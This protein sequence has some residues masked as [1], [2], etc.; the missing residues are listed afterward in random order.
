MPP[1]LERKDIEA[2]A[3]QK[4][5]AEPDGDNVVLSSEPVFSIYSVNEQ[6]FL[7]FLAGLAAL[8][9][10]LS[11]NV[12]YSAL[13][14]LA[15]HFDTSLS[16][17]NLTITTYL[18]FQGAAPTLV[19]SLSD[20][21]GRRPLYLACFVVYI[22]ANIGLATQD[23]YA[24]LLVLRMLQSTGSSG[25]VAL[26]SALVSDLVTSAQRGS[27]ISYVSMTAMVGPSFGPVIGGLLDEYL[28]WRAIFWFLTIFAGATFVLIFVVLPETCR[29]VVGNGSVPAP[30]WNTSV[31]SYLRLRRQRKAGIQPPSVEGIAFTK[32]GSPIQSLY[33]LFDKE[34]GI[35]LLYGAFFFCGFYM[36]QTGLPGQLQDNYGYNSLRIGLC[37]IPAGL[38]SMSASFVMG[39]FLDF[40]FKRHA[41]RLGFEFSNTRQQDLRNFP[42]ERARLEVV[43][44]LAFAAGSTV[45]ALG[46]CMEKRVF[47]AAPLVFLF[48]S[49]FF[50][51]STSSG[52][53]TMIVD[54]NRENPSSATAAMNLARCWLGA[55]GA[56]A[57]VPLLNV[58]GFGWVAV[59][60]AGV[61]ALMSP[62]V[63]CVIRWGPGWREEKRVKA[64]EK[65]A[66]ASTAMIQ[67]E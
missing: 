64:E 40:N 18:I 14:T 17:I 11:A 36:V 62:I 19:G 27:Y 39:R 41:K 25:T 8:F 61:W 3:E 10:P 32:R 29:R 30:L 42:I 47:I 54:L 31:L 46:W 55:A 23:T 43:F 48:L 52:L 16:N 21:Y 6:R 56:A 53:Q 2:I 44:P 63:L 59:F 22:I 4:P 34:S 57:V 37:Y 13:N 67:A 33:I 38:G 65:E 1:D 5:P 15:T 9:S 7:V 24:G 60:V 58:I 20:S 66:H 35:V 49:T 12:Y 26:A 45:I 51:S 28:G 50:M